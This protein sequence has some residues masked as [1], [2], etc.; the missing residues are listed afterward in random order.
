MKTT[1]ILSVHAREVIDGRGYPTV[2]VDIY[3][4]SGVLGRASVPVGLSTGMYEAQE[5]RDGGSRYRG[6]GVYKAVETVNDVIGPAIIGLD[7]IQQRHI[8]TLMINELDGTPNKS[9]L[10]ANAIVGVSMAVARAAAAGLGIPLY[11]YLNPNARVIPV[12]LFN[13]INGGKHASGNLEVQEFIIM[14]VGAGNLS[15]A[16]HIATEV[17]WTLKDLI[18]EKYGKIAANVGDEGGFVP[19]M[20]GIREP[21]DFLV[22]AVEQAGY[23]DQVVYGMDVAASHFY[24]PDKQIYD[25]NEQ[26]LSRDDMIGLYK[27]LCADYKI[28]S[29]EDPLYEDDFEGWAQLTEELACQIV[30]DDLFAT[31]YERLAKGINMKAANALLWKINQIGTLTEALDVAELAFRNSYSVMVSERSGETE[32]PI[33]ADFCVALNAGQIKTGA[34]VRGERTSKYNQLLRIEEELGALAVYAGKN[35]KW[36]LL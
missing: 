12:P 28:V 32:D 34:T 18:I 23:S 8:D 19:P 15:E 31:N 9:K 7:A 13:L 2:E 36:A 17:G 11:R 22:K 25:L 27:D 21:L 24:N 6:L 30:G 33:L 14:P 26:Q 29:I 3:L 20:H 1:K 16:L 4:E 35:F 5:I 10:G